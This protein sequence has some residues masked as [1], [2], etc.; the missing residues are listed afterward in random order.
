[1]PS[2]PA[3]SMARAAAGTSMSEVVV[4]AASTRMLSFPPAPYDCGPSA[5]SLRSATQS[6][7]YDGVMDY[8][9][10]T[11][12]ERIAD[13]Y[14]EWYKLGDTTDEAALLAELAAGG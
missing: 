3:S 14:D 8:G 7:F 2:Y 11:Y 5:K 9:P 13:V 12:G 10:E 6:S 1:M 4:N